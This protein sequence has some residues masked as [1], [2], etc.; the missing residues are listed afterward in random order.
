[1]KAK[2]IATKAAG[3][4]GGDRKEAYGDVVDGLQKIA[5]MMNAVLSVAGKS[6]AKPIEPR[7]VAML[8]VAM[9]AARVY[10]GPFRADSFIDV[11]G[12]ASVAGE[13]ASRE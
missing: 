2:E 3:L 9:K 1:M 12:W 10:T 8:M 5:T 4:V 7:D 6:P 13:A 11:A